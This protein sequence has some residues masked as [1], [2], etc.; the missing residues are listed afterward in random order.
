MP[1]EL[2]RTRAAQVELLRKRINESGLSARKFAETVLIREERTIRR[3]LKEES[4]IP[5]MV[6]DFLA[7]PWE[8]P[9]PKTAPDGL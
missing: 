8:I 1:N 9:W 4:P 6:L 5:K 2:P 3:W 7:N